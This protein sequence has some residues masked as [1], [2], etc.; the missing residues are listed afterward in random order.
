MTLANQCSFYILLTVPYTGHAVGRAGTPKEG[1]WV[2]IFASR[3][4]EVLIA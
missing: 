2:E 1:A 4:N 3:V